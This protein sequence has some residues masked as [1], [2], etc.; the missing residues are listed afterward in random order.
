MSTSHATVSTEVRR[1]MRTSHLT[2][3]ALAASLGVSQTTISK[4]L[5]AETHW[6]L[7]DIDRLRDMGVP[8]SVSA[9]QG[10]GR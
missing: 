10:A 3:A 5:R 6:S 7:A 9:G 4:K 8:V 2:Q 1:Y